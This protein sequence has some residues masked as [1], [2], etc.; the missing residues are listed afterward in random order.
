MIA[1]EYKE[2]TGC[3]L[4]NDSLTSVNLM[5]FTNHLKTNVANSSAKTY[6]SFLKSA[7]NTLRSDG[8]L[9]QLSGDWVKSLNVKA[10]QVAMCYLTEE[11]IN[12]VAAYAPKNDKE[13]M[14]RAQFLVECYTGARTSD[15]ERFDTTNIDGDFLTYVSQKTKIRATI[16]LK[17]II[18]QLIQENAHKGKEMPLKTKN[19]IIRRILKSAGVTDM[20]KVFKAGEELTGRKYEFCS[21]HTGRRSF[22]SNMYLRGVDLYTISK[23]M[24]HSSVTMTENYVCCGI[25]SLPEAALSF[26]K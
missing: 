4:T 5:L 14:I 22:A 11:E 16:P 3:E 20:C 8:Q 13:R 17:P 2:A 7:I 19:D 1:R 18:R 24:G 6:G 23:L 9:P 12:K 15:I 25:R 21:T 26:F 10:E